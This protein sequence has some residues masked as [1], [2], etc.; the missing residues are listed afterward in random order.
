LRLSDLFPPAQVRIGLKARTK[1]EA[2]E[3]L[4]ALLPL[5]DPDRCAEVVRAVLERESVLSTGIGRGVAVP[6]GKTAAAPR[7]MGA[8]GTVPDGLP[9][10]AVDGE[11]CRILI[12][13]VSD[14]DSAGPHVRALAQVARVL[15]QEKSKRALAEAKTPEDVAAVFREDER[16]EGL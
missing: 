2:I 15:N 4:V 13:L 8:L 16:R 11:P 9:F 12:L 6:H 14:P 7:L 3:E 10:D 5:P 1:N